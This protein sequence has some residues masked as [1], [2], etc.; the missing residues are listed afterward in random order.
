M[1]YYYIFESL[2]W[3]LSFRILREPIGRIQ[4]AGSQTARQWFGYMDGAVEAGQRAATEV[5][6]GCCLVTEVAMG[7]CLVTWMRQ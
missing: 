2:I 6:I 4:F 1:A 3:F 5:G 7:C